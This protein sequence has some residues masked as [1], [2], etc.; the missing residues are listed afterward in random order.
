[1][2]R[3]ASSAH[4]ASPWL[5][6]RKPPL[7]LQDMREQC[8]GAQLQSL[9]RLHSNIL[10][11][12]RLQTKSGAHDLSVKH[13]Q[14]LTMKK[15]TKSYRSPPTKVLIALDGSGLNGQTFLGAKTAPTTAA[16][17][18]VFHCK[19]TTATGRAHRSKGSGS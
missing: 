1:L 16:A 14:D 7:A 10:T 6:V 4:T 19:R 8:M 5:T 11:S 17:T 12:K 3:D 15:T 18:T 13:P 2:L 9:S